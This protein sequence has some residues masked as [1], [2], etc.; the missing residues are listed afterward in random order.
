METPTSRY[1]VREVLSTAPAVQVEWLDA[2]RSVLQREPRREYVVLDTRTGREVL[3]TWT[4]ESAL[5][6]IAGIEQVDTKHC[7]AAAES[8]RE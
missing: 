3:R 1:C 5:G 2:S 7:A 8:R 6:A 4:V